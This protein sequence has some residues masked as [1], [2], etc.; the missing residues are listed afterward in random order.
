M[1]LRESFASHQDV[2][3]FCETAVAVLEQG[4]STGDTVRNAKLVQSAGNLEE[5]LLDRTLSFEKLAALAQGPPR[6]AIQ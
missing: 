4:H 1:N 5:C 6:V 3:V 2:D